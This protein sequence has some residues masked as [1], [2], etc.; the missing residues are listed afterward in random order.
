MRFDSKF[1][2]Q[3][4][5]AP[6]DLEAEGS[7]YGEVREAMFHNA[8]YLDPRAQKRPPLPTYEVN[9]GRVIRGI[10]PGGL[11]WQ[12]KEATARAVRSTADLRR[13]P[14]GR[15]Y[16]RLLH[17]NGIA[18]FG[19]WIIDRDNPYS[20]YFQNGKRAL[21]IARYSVCCSETR[22]GHLRSQSL[23]GKLY[24][25][26]EL[27]HADKLVTAN[28]FTQEDLGGERTMYVNDVK[29][30]NAPDT[31]PWRR[32][33]G[34]PILLLSGLL[35]KVIDRE[36][37]IRQL[38]P[39][40]EL[41]NGSAPTRAPAFM[42]LTVPEDQPRIRGD[43]IDFRTEILTQLHGDCDP[44]DETKP[45]QSPLQRKLVFNI[46][47]TDH[48]EDKGLLRPRRVFP[49][50]WQQIGRIEFTEA[51]ASYNADFVLHFRH[52]PWRTDRNDPA[53]VLRKR[54][55]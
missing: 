27:H 5:L 31:T 26:D 28:F 25:T 34:F 35:F 13:G 12:F 17:P 46:E 1:L 48:G 20:G 4:G 53:T 51:V 45:G 16:R 22:R 41:G 14:D 21:I 23:A 50:G 54:A 11:P 15:G 6:E 30:R 18:L 24:P 47:V 29:M 36:P 52:P 55:T 49:E 9:W 39:I 43:E 37:T 3:Q 38:Y 10:L 32:G 44:D 19:M 33:W 2:G 42:Q 8:Y 7:R 40:A